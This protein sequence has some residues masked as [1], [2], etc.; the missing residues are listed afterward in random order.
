MHAAR[1]SLIKRS[2]GRLPLRWAAATPQPVTWSASARQLTL[3]PS[4]RHFPTGS[5]ARHTV[6]SDSQQRLKAPARG[7]PIAWKSARQT[8]AAQSLT[9]ARVR[10]WFLKWLVR[11]ARVFRCLP[12]PDRFPNVAHAVDERTSA[13]ARL[14]PFCSSRGVGPAHFR[15]GDLPDLAFQR[16]PQPLLCRKGGQA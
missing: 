13:P 12:S 1:A 6:R 2:R 16:G 3:L 4:T 15:S 10:A 14:V 11:P 7:Q 5:R 9:I 8:D